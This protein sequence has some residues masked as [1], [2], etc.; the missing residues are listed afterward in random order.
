MRDK[1][2]AVIKKIVVGLLP[3][4]KCFFVKTELRAHRN[5][6]KTAKRLFVL[7]SE[8]F[9]EMIIN[10]PMNEIKEMKSISFERLS[11]RESFA[12]KRMKIGVK[13]EIAMQLTAITSESAY[14]HERAP[15]NI[16][17]HLMI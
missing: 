15:Q 1:I 7:N 3:G 5:A 9:G 16:I 6:A 13:H 2:I 17:K 8:G 10:A 11:F 12:S 4:D 14:C